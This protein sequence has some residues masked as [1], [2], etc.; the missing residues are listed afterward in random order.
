MKHNKDILILTTGIISY[1]IL[2]I[3]LFKKNYKIIFFY[4][5][6]FGLFFLFFE[7]LAFPLTFSFLII[8]IIVNYLTIKEYLESDLL[9]DI[10]NSAEE[11]LN[12]VK[13]DENKEENTTTKCEED[14]LFRVLD[15]D[16]EPKEDE[17]LKNE[18]QKLEYET[19]TF[20]ESVVKLPDPNFH[21]INFHGK[22]LS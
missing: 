12:S 21:G 20:I 7:N 22:T 5:L 16:I 6:L 17:N 11:Q 15:E 8:I 10:K 4:F 14:I 19:K 9:E 13:I 3:E 18:Q 1:I 2:I